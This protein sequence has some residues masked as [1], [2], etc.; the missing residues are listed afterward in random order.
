[1][2]IGRYRIHGISRRF[3]V[4]LTLFVA[5]VIALIMALPGGPKSQPL[6]DP[7]LPPSELPSLKDGFSANYISAFGLERPTSAHAIDSSY[8]SLLG[9]PLRLRVYV[10]D[11]QTGQQNRPDLYFN[12]PADGWTFEPAVVLNPTQPTASVD[13][14]QTVS[15]A[16]SGQDQSDTPIQV[17]FRTHEIPPAG[18]AYEITGI[19]WWRS[20]RVN[21]NSQAQQ[22]GQAGPQAQETPAPTILVDSYVSL[23]QN[24][25]Q[26]P[27]TQIA[28]LNLTYGDGPLQMTIKWLEWSSGKQ[29]RACVQVHNSSS[30]PNTDWAQTVQSMTADIGHG[31]VTGQPDQNSALSNQSQLDGGATIPG[32]VLFDQSVANPQQQLTLRFPALDQNSQDQTTPD[33]V[34]VTVPTGEIQNVQT[35]QAATSTPSCTTSQSAQTTTPPVSS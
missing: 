13:L 5:A 31:E 16:L 9:L 6:Y 2:R 20:D 10:P 11:Q 23:D 1:M 22:Q 19:L 30:T 27:T 24:E 12:A 28:N 25:L 8:T 7:A 17:A 35:S 14:Q 33:T 21:P 3:W 32:E 18:A 26:A 15:D 4:I 29:L 34:T